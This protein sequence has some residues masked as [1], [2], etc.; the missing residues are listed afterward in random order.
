MTTSPAIDLASTDYKLNPWPVYERLRRETPVLHMPA[1]S[2]DGEDVYALSRYEDVRRALRDKA[3]FSSWIRRDDVMDLPMLV[4]RDAPEHTRLR[5]LTNQAFN[6]RLV[7]TLGDWVQDV[8]D[9]MIGDLL[10]HDRVELVDTYTTALPLRVVGG[11]LGIPLDRKADLRRWSQAVM[12]AFAVTAGLDPELTPGFFEDILE[13]GNYMSELAHERQNG[14]VRAEDILGSLV[15]QH[16]EGVL[17]WDELVTLAWSF[18][19]AGH[20]TTMNLLGGGMHMLITEPALAH[21][22]TR[23]P[24]LIPEFAEEYLRM[25]APTQWLLR[26]TTT[27]VEIEGVTIPAGALVHVLLGSANRD[28]LRWPDPDVFDL[29]R[30]EKEKH[31]AFGAGPHFCPGAELS[32]LL[33]ECTFRTFLP[34]ADRFRPDPADPPRMRTQQGSYGFTRIP[35]LVRPA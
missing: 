5:R 23:E 25:Y 35:L 28:P 20:E 21:R 29:D 17:D 11:M 19:A 33:A 12:N 26:R 27:D 31:M 7:R 30:P 22:L 13:F 8:V 10:R 34:V 14:Q 1:G 18:V 4:N 9:G 6:A 2:W 16:A 3:S 32:R 15:A 24:E